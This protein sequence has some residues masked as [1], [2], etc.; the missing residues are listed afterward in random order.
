MDDNLKW[1]TEESYPCNTDG[2]KVVSLRTG[3]TLLW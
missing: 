1:H 3:H 2:G